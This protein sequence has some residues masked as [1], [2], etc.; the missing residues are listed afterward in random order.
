VGVIGAAVVLFLVAYAR[1]SQA[2][3]VGRAYRAERRYLRTTEPLPLDIAGLAD[4]A[5]TDSDIS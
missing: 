4:G 3:R 5:G 1:Q 2:M